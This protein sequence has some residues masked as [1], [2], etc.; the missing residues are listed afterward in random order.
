METKEKE[1]IHIYQKRNTCF[2]GIDMH[3]DIH[4]AVIIDC[5]MNKL[6]EINFENRPSKFPAFVEDVRKICGT[7]E[8]VFGLEDTRG[9]G[10]NLAA[11]L[12]GRRFGVKHVNPA[13]AS[14]VRLAN[15]IIYKDDSYDAY[16]VARVLRDMVDTLQDAKMGL[17]LNRER[18]SLVILTVRKLVLMEMLE[19]FTMRYIR[20]VSKLLKSIGTV[21]NTVVSVEFEKMADDLLMITI[22]NDIKNEKRIFNYWRLIGNGQNPPLEIG[23][24]SDKKIIHSITVFVDR[25]NFTEEKKLN[26][27]IKSG[28]ILIDTDLFQNDRYVDAEGLYYVFLTDRAFTCI[29][30]DID[31]IRERV[32]NG[33]VEYLITNN[34]ELCGFSIC[35]L[36]NKELDVIKSL[37]NQ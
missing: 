3:K 21:L 14:A 19:L 31:D 16:C 9:F 11:Y 26:G 1:M 27:T 8:F 12:V 33:R 32:L 17:M 22:N 15:P 37:S 29:F 4:C 20:E 30:N 35:N 6:G 25:E 28:N 10:R 18:T 24:D 2:I 23:V 36:D 13:Y 7:K 34:N 5:W